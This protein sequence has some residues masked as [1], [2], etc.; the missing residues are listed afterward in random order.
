L[1]NVGNDADSNPTI[2]DKTMLEALTALVAGFLLLSG[3]W[4]KR[5]ADGRAGTSLRPVEAIVGLV[6][7]IVGLLGILS[8][9]GI[10][11]FLAGVTLLIGAMRGT[12][13]GGAEVARLSDAIMPFRA[14]LGLLTL[15]IG[16]VLLILLADTSG[17]WRGRVRLTSAPVHE[18][19]LTAVK[20]PVLAL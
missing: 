20:P 9:V 17:R 8:V 2:E 4:W 1:L 6:A 13:R 12:G 15:V 3:F 11:L 10:V 14:L 16:I 7:L 18:W 5:G 19:Q